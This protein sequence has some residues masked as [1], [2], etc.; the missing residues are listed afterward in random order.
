MNYPCNHPRSRSLAGLAFLLTTCAPE[1]PDLP[2]TAVIPTPE[3]VAYQ[4]M[5]F[6]GF[7]HFSMNTFTDREWGFG[8]EPA[9][10]FDPTELDTDQWARVAAAVGM[11]E[12]ILTAKHHDGFTLWPSAFSHHSV[13]EGPWRGGRGDVVAE[14]VE[15]ARRHNLEVG[16]YL[17]PWDRNHPE[18]GREDYLEAYRGQLTE[19]LTRYGRINEI[20]VDGANGGTGYYGGANEERR[21]DRRTYYRWPETVSVVKALQPHTL[22]FSDAGPDIRWIGNERGFAGETNWSTIDTDSVVIGEA[23][24]EYLN[25]GDPHGHQWVVPLCDTSIRPGWFYHADQD[26]QVKSPQELV[27]LYYRSVGRNCV[28]LL[29]VPPDRRGRFHETDVAAL[30]EF[31]RILDETFATNLVAGAGADANNVRHGHLKFW[32]THLVD[33]DPATYWATDD[34]RR[35]AVLELHLSTEATFDRILL[36]EPIHLGQRISS[37]A[38]EALVDGEWLEVGRGTTVGYKRILRVPA[39]TTSHLRL[40]VEDALAPPTLSEF[41]LY[42]ASEG[43]GWTG[44]GQTGAG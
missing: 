26:G 14:L 37:F 8:D 40:I 9:E 6:L 27:D 33:G 39:V 15:S 31:R 11:G 4:E 34:D 25:T 13:A 24:T 12:L 3:Q 18:Y 29:N 5:E 35:S 7:V 44:E 17:S 32:P 16:L 38:V 1:P 36:Q 28:L 10:L 23:D 30:R 41:G 42:R 43:E 21:I 19:L 22:I 20:W 2:P